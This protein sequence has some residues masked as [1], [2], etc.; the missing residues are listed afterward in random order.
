MRYSDVRKVAVHCFVQVWEAIVVRYSVHG[1]TVVRYLVYKC[2]EPF[3]VDEG[4]VAVSVRAPK[5]K[6][7]SRALLL[8]SLMMYWGW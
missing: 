7:A 5:V 1:E 3:C 2:V 4:E 6:A 8:I